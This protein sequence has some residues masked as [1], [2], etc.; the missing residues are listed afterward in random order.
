MIRLPHLAQ[1]T[2]ARFNRNEVFD[3]RLIRGDVGISL[4]TTSNRLNCLEITSSILFRDGPGDHYGYFWT[5]GRWEVSADTSAWEQFL[6]T[7]RRH[8]EKNKQYHALMEAFE[9]Q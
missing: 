4:R 9:I 2:D 7:N 6:G 5:I 1:P 3:L 8:L